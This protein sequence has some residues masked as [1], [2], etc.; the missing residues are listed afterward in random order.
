[1][2]IAV[3]TASFGRAFAEKKLALLDFPALC[4]RFGL[5]AM[6]LNDFRLQGDWKV[7]RELKR[8]AAK[9][10]LGICA[11]AIENNYYRATEA[12]IQK[13]RQHIL[14]Y[15]DVAYFLGAPL[16][17]VDTSPYGKGLPDR[18]IPPVVTHEMAFERAV[19]TFRDLMPKAAEKGITF[20]LENHGGISRTS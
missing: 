2:N 8:R 14:N 17:R 9:Y 18:I 7:I 13:E 10:G 16:L 19:R 12:E 4:D 11:V 5:E 3:S 15:L 6:E 20:V 1:M